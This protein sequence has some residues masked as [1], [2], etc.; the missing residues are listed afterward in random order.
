MNECEKNPCSNGGTCL[1]ELGSYRCVCPPSATG[2]NCG[3][4]AGYTTGLHISTHIITWEQL[5]W[6]G[7][8][9][10]A[11]VFLV[12][13]FVTCRRIRSKRTRTRANNINNETRKQIV[14]NSARPNEHEYKRSSKLSNLEVV[15]VRNPRFYLCICVANDV[16]LVCE[17]LLFT[18]R[19]LLQRECPPQCPP[20]P[21]SY[22]P[23]SNNEQ[24]LLS[25]AAA[26]A[27]NNLDTLRSY[28]S[29]GDELENFPPDYLRNL[30]RNT[31]LTQPQIPT[32]D[33]PPIEKPSWQEQM[34]LASLI[35]D[36]TKIKNGKDT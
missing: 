16:A 19:S 28:G 36:A 10:L 24:V 5:V 1:N 27:L 17:Q 12:I 31:V 30:N 22:T 15:Q 33:L 26:V 14:L 35:S 4:P 9:I 11:N 23:S 32:I 6:I 2:M 7:V 29:A 3:N 20:R 13:L 8:A 18:S 25:S 21:A 34:Q